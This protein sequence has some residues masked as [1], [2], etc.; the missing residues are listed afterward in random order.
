[1][2]LTLA[3]GSDALLDYFAEASGG[4][5]VRVPPA[6]AT[7]AQLGASVREYGEML[8][9]HA[10]MLEDGLVTPDEWDRFARE[11]DQAM[12][13]IQALKISVQARVVLPVAERRAS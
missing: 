4:L 9:V 8:Q 6:D 7:G 1:M 5:F 3:S 12:A 2:A 10:A 13:A 11:A